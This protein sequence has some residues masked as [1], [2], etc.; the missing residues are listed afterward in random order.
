MLGEFEHAAPSE[1]V[2]IMPLSIANVGDQVAMRNALADA[3]INTINLTNSFPITGST[4]TVPGRSITVNGNGHAINHNT[5][6][7]FPVFNLQAN[8]TL[9]LE[10]VI[11]DGHQIMGPSGNTWFGGKRGVTVNASNAHLHMRQ[12]AIIRNFQSNSTPNEVNGLAVLVTGGGTFTM[13]DGL[14]D[15]NRGGWHGVV[16]IGNVAPATTSGTFTMNGGQISNNSATGGGAISVYNAGARFYMN[17]G[18]INGN[19]SYG[20]GGGVRLAGPAHSVTI[21]GGIIEN[22]TAVANGGGIATHHGS[23]GD[24]AGAIRVAGGTIRN[25]QATNGAGIY[26]IGGTLSFHQ[27]TISGNIASNNGGGVNIAATTANAFNIQGADLKTITGNTAQDGGGIW[28][29]NPPPAATMNMTMPTTASGLSITNNTATNTGGGIF[30]ARYQYQSPLLN[31]SAVPAPYSNLSLRNV[32]F[33]GNTAS[34]EERPPMNAESA[35][36]TTAF[37]STSIQAHLLNNYDI[38]FRA[39]VLNVYDVAPKGSTVATSTQNLIITFDEAVNI[40]PLGLTWATVTLN[41]VELDLSTA[42]WSAGNTML[43][44]PFPTPLTYSTSYTVVILD[45]FSVLGGAM[46]S[47]Y[48]HVFATEGSVVITKRLLTPEGTTTPNTTFT[49]NI[50]P[51][52]LNGDE[53]TQAISYL[54]TLHNNNEQQVTYT[55]ADTASV[56][57]TN[58]IVIE[59]ISQNLLA[60]VE[61]P[62]AGIFSYRVTETSGG[63]TQSIDSG[64]M[65]FD[66]S[67]YIITFEVVNLTPLGTGHYV[68]SVVIH[69]I[70]NESL[71]KVEGPLLFTNTFIRE[72]ELRVSKEV[73]GPLANKTRYFDFELTLRAPYLSTSATSPAS[74]H[75]GFR[76]E[77]RDILTGDNITSASNSTNLQGTAPNYYL[78]FISGVTQ[79][80]HLRHNQVLVFTNTE[81]GT[82]YNVTETGVAN[83]RAE[84]IVTTAN[85][86]S[87][88]QTAA[89][90][91]DLSITNQLVGEGINRADFVNT[92]LFTPPVGLVTGSFV[93]V[94]FVLLIA[95]VVVATTAALKRRKRVEL[96]ILGLRRAN[97]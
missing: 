71:T 34:T 30:T 94:I 70:E 96:E 45:F 24:F 51:H 81:V 42:T 80:V 48:T 95:G 8:A 83:Y 52:A 10:N 91:E 77:V 92:N 14:I 66:P 57:A 37:T 78:L 32:A 93:S 54:P 50:Q 19:H 76:A 12:G 31:M 5:A 21:D 3:T 85:T 73:V 39:G 41:G 56:N 29:A 36:P 4:F 63:T 49:F 68:S 97:I 55:Q 20:S 65:Y 38:N 69:R 89:I 25:N 75:A 82:R 86:I 53:S 64:T 27:G 9:N 60:Q 46:L 1:F 2:G 87:L 11:L 84:V 13:W 90:G 47:P 6:G 74:P 15:N 88:E 62:F 59:K 23:A 28:L 40:T 44:I 18:R 67:E 16:V 43:S 61:F 7:S 79:T 58:T 33:S 35:I 26:L 22:N 72:E 17:D